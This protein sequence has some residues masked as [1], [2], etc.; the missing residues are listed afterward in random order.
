MLLSQISLTL[1]LS[2]FVFW[3]GFSVH[4]TYTADSGH[5]GAARKHLDRIFLFFG[6]LACLALSIVGAVCDD[7]HSIQC[8]GNKT[9]HLAAAGSFFAIYTINMLVL[10]VRTSNNQNKYCGFLL[11]LAIFS[12]VLKLRF[13]PHLKASALFE[14][15]DVAAI[16]VWTS[17]YFITERKNFTLQVTQQ[18]HLTRQ[19]DTMTLVHI[20]AAFLVTVVFFL[21]LLTLILSHSLAT[22]EGYVFISDTF[23]SPPG[24]WISRWS[25][26]VIATLSVWVHICIYYMDGME[27]GKNGQMGRNNVVDKGILLISVF[28]MVGMCVMGCSSQTESFAVHKSGAGVF[29]I[30][31]DVFMV[32]HCVRTFMIGKS[33]RIVTS[34]LLCLAIFACV[35]TV[36]VACAVPKFMMRPRPRPTALPITMEWINIVVVFVYMG[37]AVFKHARHL[38]DGVG[39]SIVHLGKVEEANSAR[40]L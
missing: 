8:L 6:V 9:L 29:Y 20:S 1:A 23:L 38:V 30:L 19:G 17:I 28:A 24:N 12:A 40:L 10:S 25:I 11:F 33:N 21:L 31:Y 15:L 14:W 35:A 32:A 13:I 22:G 3:N 37:A 5:V 2:Q 18:T 26:P 16:L 7:E 39:V 36:I 4:R 27:A 34:V